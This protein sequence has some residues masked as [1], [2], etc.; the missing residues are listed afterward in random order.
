MIFDRKVIKLLFFRGKVRFKL[1]I[2]PISKLKSGYKASINYTE[3]GKYKR[4]SKNG[5]KTQL[6]AKQWVSQMEVLYHSGNLLSKQD[7]YFLDYFDIWVEKHINSGIR[8]QTQTNYNTAKVNVK[9]FFPDVKLHEIN[10]NVLQTFLNRF[11]QSHTAS[12][13]GLLFS[14]V[15]RAIK[16]AYLDGLIDRDPTEY[17]YKISSLNKSKRKEL[18]YLEQDDYE[19]LINYIETTSVSLINFA[20]YTGLLSGLRVG[21]ILA[22]TETD[23]DETDQTLRVDKSKTDKAPIEYN[24]PKTQSSIR[25]IK[26][27]QKFFDYFNKLKET[28]DNLD[29]HFFGEKSTQKTISFGLRKLL[30]NAQISKTITPHG[31]RHTHASIL[32]NANVDIAYVSERLG[33]SNIAITQ[34]VY[35]HLL[36]DTRTKEEDKAIAILQK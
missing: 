17:K 19:K 31:L 5:F 11:T 34:K 27:P 16:D 23:L 15:K 26:M 28:N 18:K 3:D 22:L 9:K 8:T 29:T 13:T 24:I 20:I 33:H 30:K 25:T 1:R 7:M 10:R 35:F 21:E 14:Q 2:M 36:Q 32:I 6:E 4:K 12:T